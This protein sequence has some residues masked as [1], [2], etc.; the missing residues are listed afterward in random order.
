MKKTFKEFYP[1]YLSLHKNRRCRRLHFIGQIFTL[2]LLAGIIIYSAWIF[3][4][5]LP[6][7]IYPFAWSGHFFYEKNKPA[8][9]KQPVYSKLADW[10]MFKDIFLGKIKV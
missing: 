1:Y 5:G 10:V 6:L 7:V 9:F 4:L 2:S 3:L 8:A